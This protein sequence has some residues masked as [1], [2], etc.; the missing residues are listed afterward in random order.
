MSVFRLIRASTPKKRLGVKH[1]FG[2]SEYHSGAEINDWLKS[3]EEDYPGKVKVVIG[4]RSYEGRDIV[5]VKLSLKEGN[6]AV[7]I[8]GGRLIKFLY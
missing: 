6:K 5:G 7:F 2:W 1:A 8:E 4:G 3:L